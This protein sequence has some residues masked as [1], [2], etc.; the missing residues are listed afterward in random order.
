MAQLGV[1]AVLHHVKSAD[2]CGHGTLLAIAPDGLSLRFAPL[3]CGSWLCKRCAQRKLRQWRAKIMDARPTRWLTLTLDR[4]LYGTP[5]FML[6][7]FKRAFPKL[8]RAIRKCYGGFEYV[9][10][11]ER[12]KNGFPHLH[13]AFRGTYIPQKWLSRAW[14]Q[15][16]YSPIVDVRKIP[17]ERTLAHYITKYIIKSAASTALHFPGLRIITTSRAFIP[18]DREAVAT[19]RDLGWTVFHVCLDPSEVL[20]SL[21]LHYRMEVRSTEKEAT[22]ELCKGTPRAPPLHLDKEHSIF[23]RLLQ[24]NMSCL[25]PKK[26]SK[27]RRS[28]ATTLALFTL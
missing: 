14:K 19:L 9:A 24:E 10:I 28:R 3:F 1:A 21:A 27:P 13:V 17:N 15:L 11:Y 23:H 18:P 16:T 6:K 8:V 4:K 26:S 2:Y 22:L 5:P 20:D 12:H 25:R 7:A